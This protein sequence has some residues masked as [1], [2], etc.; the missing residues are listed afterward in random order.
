M[1]NNKSEKILTVST[2]LMSEKGFAGTS[3]QEI[4]N[5][6]GLH[7]SS[8]FHYFSDKNELLKRVL[9]RS[10]IEVL[11][12][13]EMMMSDENLSPEK[14]LES[15]IQNHLMSVVKYR[16]D[17]NLYL[18]EFRNLQR[19]DQQKYLKK[20]KKYEKAFIKIVDEL[21]LKGYFEGLDSKIVAFGILG[22]L[23][24]VVKWFRSDGQLKI[25]KIS[26][27]F[28]KMIIKSY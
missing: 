18:N 16:D 25:E 8:L 15:A 20:R 14:K 21:K 10:T 19:R 24:W 17:V 27:I 13:L 6:V 9:D 3:L 26:N 1:K 12:N 22:M 4:A 23:N 7:K 11:K 28:C 5:K 2:K